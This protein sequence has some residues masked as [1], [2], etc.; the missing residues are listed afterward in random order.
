MSFNN[1]WFGKLF[2]EIHSNGFNNQSIAHMQQNVNVRRINGKPR[3][4]KL[5]LLAIGDLNTGKT[6]ILR[7]YVYKGF[8]GFTEPTIG[9]DIATKWVKVD[10]IKWS[11]SLWDIAGQE[12]FIGLTRTYFKNALGA[13]VV[14]DITDRRSLRNA[15]K[16]KKDLDNKVFLPNGHNIPSILLANKW[17]LI[18]QNT[19]LRQYSDQELDEFCHDNGFMAWFATSAKSGKN[20]KHAMHRIIHETVNY[21]LSNNDIEKQ[22]SIDLRRKSMVP[23]QM[24]NNK[25]F[26]CSSSRNVTY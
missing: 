21:V 12:R 1:A 17:D 3:S 18:E 11:V 20:V 13:I 5:K 6:S 25:C 14:F 26:S 7:R 4:T 16:W 8:D 22:Q 15:K 9:M 2:S 24:E 10:Q 23:V 19:S